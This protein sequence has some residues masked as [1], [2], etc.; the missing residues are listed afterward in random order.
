MNNAPWRTPGMVCYH[1]NK[2][3][4]TA[5]TYRMRK[6]LSDNIPITREGKIDV[7]TIQA[8]MNKTWK[9]KREEVS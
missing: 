2:L 6:N 4:H 5:R 1:C 3:G 9:K 8:G 7:E